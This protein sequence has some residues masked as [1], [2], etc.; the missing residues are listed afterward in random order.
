MRWLWLKFGS[1]DG[2]TIGSGSG[3]CFVRLWSTAGAALRSIETSSEVR[4]LAF[5]PDSQSVL[6]GGFNGTATLYSLSGVVLYQLRPHSK[7]CHGVAF[8]AG[9]WV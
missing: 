7:P 9:A 4:A 8:S 6:A 1:A 5:A 2:L 3:D